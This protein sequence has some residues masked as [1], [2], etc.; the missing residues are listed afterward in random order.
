MTWAMGSLCSGYEGLGAG[1]AAALGGDCELAYTADSDPGAAAILAC[2]YPGVPNLGDIRQIRWE[3]LPPVDV[4]CAGF[5][6]QPASAAGR[7]G[8]LSDER[9][10]W[11]AIADGISRMGTRPRLLVLE[12]VPGLLSVGHGRA[13]AQV[14][15]SLACLGYVFRYGVYPA[16]GVG[17]PHLRK[18]L[19]IAAWDHHARVPAAHAGGQRLDGREGC[20]GAGRDQHE[21]GE[22]GNYAG[23]GDS[24]S[25]ADGRDGHGRLTLLKTPTAQLAAN[26][27]SQ[28]PEKRRAGGHGPTLDDQVSWEL[29]PT[30]TARAKGGRNARH[31]DPAHGDDLPEA[32]RHLLPTPNASDCKGGNVPAGRV[33][34]SGRVRKAGDADLPEAVSALAVEWGKYGPAIRRWEAILGREAPCPVEP[35]KNGNRRLSPEFASWMMGLPEG[36]VTGVPG[37]T[38]AQQ[39]RAIGNGVVP[40]QAELA[41]RHLLSPVVRRA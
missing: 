36:F 41:V 31:G 13:M 14:I 34:P 37:L 5:P 18:R 8:G 9:W 7:R 1:V 10:L 35:G 23:Y 6:C 29:L 26:G 16:S 3:D 28:H 32:V 33:R 20:V 22:A 4:L 17:A 15:Y 30:P 40:Q 24:A 11:P 25:A 27:G 19:F 39:L 2:R 12:N 21:R 38:R